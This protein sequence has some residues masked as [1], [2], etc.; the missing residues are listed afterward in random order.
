MYGTLG[1]GAYT[2]LKKS[3]EHLV[4]YEPKSLDELV[5]RSMKDSFTTAIIPLSTNSKVR[6]KYI[7][8]LNSIRFGRLMEDMDLF[9][10]I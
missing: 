1:S 4:E 8:F 3:R 2:P 7:T 6:Q 9:A 10:G 5:P